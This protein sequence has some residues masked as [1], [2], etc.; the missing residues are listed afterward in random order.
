M[1]SNREFIVKFITTT[2][3]LNISIKFHQCWRKIFLIYPIDKKRIEQKIVS[4]LLLASRIIAWM[5]NKHDFNEFC[6]LF[7]D[8]QSSWTTGS[9]FKATGSGCLS[10]PRYGLRK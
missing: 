6:N 5:D 7:S 1:M 3:L 9:E 2:S 8:K 10:G 4:L